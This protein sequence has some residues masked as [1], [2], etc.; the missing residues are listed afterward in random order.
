MNDVSR[1]PLGPRALKWGDAEPKAVFLPANGFPVASY[2]FLLSPLAKRWPLLGIENRGVWD[3]APPSQGF[4]WASHAADLLEL[5]GQGSVE[6]PIVGMG[7]SIGATV[8]A[9][10]ARQHPEQF[11]ALV[12][13]DPAT[14]PGR[15]LPLL[16]R[17]MP[18]LT[19]RMDLVTRTRNRREIWPDA[20]AFVSYHREKSVFRTFSE[21]A[22]A[23]YAKA[24]LRESGAAYKLAY[25]REW[26]AWNFQHTAVFWP[27]V[28][29]LPMP[30]LILRGETSYL[31]PASEFA[32]NSRRLP[33]HIQ[34]VTVAG[35]GHMLPQE[36]PEEVLSLVSDWLAVLD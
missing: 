2:D 11:R 5:L 31:H 7:H 36:A 32:R 15:W 3:E 20:E 6:Q 30:T 25:C 4:N 16:V 8:T 23:D 35:A 1:P 21:Q 18:S 24:A 29:K 26:E 33:D 17:L 12:L 19:K 34:A 10:A 27:V 28:R 9:M 14:V 22:M 13:I